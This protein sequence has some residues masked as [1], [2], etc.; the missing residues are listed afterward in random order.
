MAKTVAVV[1]TDD[2][3]GSPHARTVRFGYQGQQFE[4]DL[5]DKNHVA[6]LASLRPFIAA[7]RLDQARW[8]P[9]RTT[10]SG[11]PGSSLSVDSAA[12]RAWAD[13]QGIDVAK[14]GRIR[15][16]VLEKY[17]AAHEH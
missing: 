15:V 3:D 5:A 17:A 10:R 7:A 8:R 11:R 2:I 9:R 1:L 16:D 12:V 6:F 13:K 14:R 4:I